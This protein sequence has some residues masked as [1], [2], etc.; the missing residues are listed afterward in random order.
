LRSSYSGSWK[1]AQPVEEFRLEDLL[2]AV[3][4]VA[5]EPD[6]L[7]LGEA[8]RARIVELRAQFALVDLVGEPHRLVRLISVKVASTSRVQ[9]QIICSISSL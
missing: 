9:A 8:Q 4:R 7:L 5:G 3:E 6:H 1:S 2:A